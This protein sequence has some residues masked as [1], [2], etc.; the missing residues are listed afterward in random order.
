MDNFATNLYLK[1]LD[2]EERIESYTI[3]FSEMMGPGEN[4]ILSASFS[5]L[6]EMK[7]RIV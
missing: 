2:E 5:T 4:K 1:T 7:V 6:A 3:Y